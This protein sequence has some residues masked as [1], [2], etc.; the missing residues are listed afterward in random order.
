VKVY[1]YCGT[2]LTNKNELRP[3]IKKKKRGLLL[4]ALQ[5]LVGL[6]LF[7]F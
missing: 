4:P 5:S 7:Y 1:T 3:E 2:V 6:S